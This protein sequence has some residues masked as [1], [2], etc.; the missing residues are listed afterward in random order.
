M[1]KTPMKQAHKT[2]LLK[3]LR[4]L[5]EF[6]GDLPAEKLEELLGKHNPHNRANKSARRCENAQASVE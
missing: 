5:G 1:K 4:R 6:P 3:K 2:R